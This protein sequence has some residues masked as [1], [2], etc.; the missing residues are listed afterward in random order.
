MQQLTVLK[1]NN[2][3]TIDKRFLI[4]EKVNMMRNISTCNLPQI[5]V[6]SSYQ[7]QPTPSVSHANTKSMKI[8]MCTTLPFTIKEAVT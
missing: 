7:H 8:Q 1:N 5:L 3:G 4:S 2:I 6:I